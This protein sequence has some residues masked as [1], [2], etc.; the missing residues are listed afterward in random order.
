MADLDQQGYFRKAI[1]S[2]I[3][4]LSDLVLMTIMGKMV[5]A[6]RQPIFHN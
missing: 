6:Q 5:K 1:I 3:N 2:S 4:I